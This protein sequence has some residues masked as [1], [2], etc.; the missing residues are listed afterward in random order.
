MLGVRRGKGRE[1]LYGPKLDITVEDGHVCAIVGLD[2]RPVM[3]NHPAVVAFFESF[4][5]A[6]RRDKSRQVREQ[7][8][9]RAG[10]GGPQ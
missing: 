3:S 5:E 2:D 6:L 1:F 10:R 8:A 7:T 9:A 4:D